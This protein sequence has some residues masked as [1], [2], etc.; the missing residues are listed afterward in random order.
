MSL[1]EAPWRDPVRLDRI[2]AG[3]ERKLEADAETCARVASFLDLLEL[4][5]FSAELRLRPYGPGWRL[6]GRLRSEGTQACGLTL[7]PLPF[8]IDRT[9]HVDMAEAPRAGDKQVIDVE[10]SLDDDA[11]DLIE[12]GVIDLGIYAVEQLGLALDPFPRKPG[13]EFVP[14]EG[15]QEPSPFAVLATLKPRESDKG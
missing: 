14:P 5:L 12:D 6:S 11:P 7:E 2:G 9:F 8:Q 4:S 15:P 1:P 13:A 10:V 3:I